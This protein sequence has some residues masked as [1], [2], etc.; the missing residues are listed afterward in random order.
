[1][2]IY[3]YRYGY[4]KQTVCK[5]CT[6]IMLAGKV[7]SQQVLSSSLLCLY[8]FKV[9][10]TEQNINEIKLRKKTDE[11]FVLSPSGYIYIYFVTEVC[12]QLFQC[13]SVFSLFLVTESFNKC[14]TAAFPFS[15]SE[16]H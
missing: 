14:Y 12:L 16:I 10:E 6:L 1:M 11:L 4:L 8:I 9:N 2:N 3:D 13:F 7:F 15:P 5:L